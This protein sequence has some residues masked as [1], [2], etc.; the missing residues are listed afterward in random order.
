MVD[1]LVR[2]VDAA[3]ARELKKK[4]A[5]KG[6]SLSEAAREALAAYVRPDRQEIW[7]QA[8][9]LRRRIGKMSGDS[10]A[11]IRADRANKER[12]R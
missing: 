12:H 4:A 10:T 6:A 3:V 1:I 11:D 9:H 7:R 5:A 2:N 8:D